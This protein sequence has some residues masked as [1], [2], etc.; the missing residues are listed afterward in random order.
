MEKGEMGMGEKISAT[1]ITVGNEVLF[2]ETVDTNAAFMGRLLTEAGVDIKRK[3]SVPDDIRAIA[4][5]IRQSV[6]DILILTGGLGPTT[7]D[8]TREALALAFKVKLCEGP[9]QRKRLLAFF[10]RFRRPLAQCNFRQAMVPQGFTALD[11]SAGTAPVLFKRRPFIFALPG[12]PH[13]MEAAMRETVIPGIKAAFHLP[14]IHH[15]EIKT[16]GIGESSLQE[17]IQ[18]LKPPPSV[19][20]AFLPE[21]SGVMIRLSG[22]DKKEL[23]RFA[24]S[25]GKRCKEFIY[26]GRGETL[27]GILL[28]RFV[29][30][31]RTLAVAESCTGG[32]ISAKLTAIPGSSAYFLGGVVAYG[33][34]LKQKLLD[35][36]GRILSQKGAVS[37]ECALAMAKGVRKRTR[38]DVGLS[39]T[40]IAGPS[41]GSKEKPVGT[42]FIAVASG[43][44]SRVE[45]FLLFGKRNQIQ[46]RAAYAA[47]NMLRRTLI[48]S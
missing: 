11:N 20:L 36:P 12:V 16:L 15:V 1:L 18:D 34:S 29:R 23:A 45:K 37:G 39:I 5:E 9:R 40:G 21:F 43:K 8:L 6:S 14:P 24:L 47:L 26:A 35:V 30:E 2:G 17:R 19:T 44:E 38:A 32:R 48:S 22:K 42:V 13:E 28:E 4:R 7:D 25:I 10:R 3:I 41:G 31:K 27:E 33:N 46:E